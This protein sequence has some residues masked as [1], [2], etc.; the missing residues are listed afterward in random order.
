MPMRPSTPW[1]VYRDPVSPVRL[2]G[3]PIP[4]DSSIVEHVAGVMKAWA[5]RYPETATALQNLRLAF[6]EP[7]KS[8]RFADEMVDLSTYFTHHRRATIK[9]R[10]RYKKEVL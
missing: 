6:D 1:N 2:A 7:L 9:P 4:K 8:V 5:E 10:T 3:Q